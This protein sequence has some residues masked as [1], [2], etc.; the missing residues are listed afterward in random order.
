[1]ASLAVSRSAALRARPGGGSTAYP[2]ADTRTMHA[3]P[4]MNAFIASLSTILPLAGVGAAVYMHQQNIPNL[5]AAGIL[6]AFLIEAGVFLAT[7]SSAVRSRLATLPPARL[8]ALLTLVTPITWLL[9]GGG[10]WWQL[11]AT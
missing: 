6:F 9:A 4:R 11:A 2:M 7:G 5:Q 1:M 8:A 3:A 10:E